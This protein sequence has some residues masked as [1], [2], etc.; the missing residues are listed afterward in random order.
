MAD[1]AGTDSQVLPIAAA[2]A[3]LRVSSS[4]AEDTLSPVILA[5]IGRIE[6]FLGRSLVGADG[7]A[8]A[9]E[10]PAIVVHCVK[11]A[12]SD[13]WI[14]REA[15]ELTDDQLRPIIGRYQRLSVG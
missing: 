5:A 9:P 1:V 10:V 3:H 11:L 15:P 13:F 7:W 2:R 6:G 14:N 12:L 8:T 4:I